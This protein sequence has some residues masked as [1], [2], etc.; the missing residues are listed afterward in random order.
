MP[1]VEIEVLNYDD[2]LL[3]TN[4]SDETV[5]VRGYEREPYIRISGDGTVQVNK[6]SPSFYLNED[7]FAQVEVPGG[8]R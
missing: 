8:C 4:K 3:L 7:R 1:G 2:R 5:L 6:R